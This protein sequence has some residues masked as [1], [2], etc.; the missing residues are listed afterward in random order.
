MITYSL[1]GNLNVK[2]LG[3]RLRGRCQRLTDSVT[4]SLGSRNK[5]FHHPLSPLIFSI[6]QSF[7]SGIESSERE[8]DVFEPVEFNFFLA[9]SLQ[10]NLIGIRSEVNEP[11]E[12]GHREVPFERETSDALR[13][14]SFQLLFTE[15]TKSRGRV[16]I[17]KKHLA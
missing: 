7:P 11:K 3:E 1:V 4:S 12:G 2:E 10:I 15:Q 16:G 9:F 17:K 14:S 5:G 8:F 13:A 6:N